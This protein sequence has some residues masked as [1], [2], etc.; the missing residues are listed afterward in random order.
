MNSNFN[1]DSYDDAY[2]IDG[3][4]DEPKL[5]ALSKPMP[6]ISKWMSNRSFITINY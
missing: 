6:I 2:D 3:N 1:H 4:L 5:L